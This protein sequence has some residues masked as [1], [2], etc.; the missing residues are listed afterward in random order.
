VNGYAVGG[1]QPF[2]RSEYRVSHPGDAG[3]DCTVLELVGEL[4][5]E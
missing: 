5:A 2:A 1:W 3:D 4:A